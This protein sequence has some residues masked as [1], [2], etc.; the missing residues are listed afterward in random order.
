[1][2]GISEWRPSRFDLDGCNRRGRAAV[3][4]GENN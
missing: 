3:P 4:Y 1:L 2:V